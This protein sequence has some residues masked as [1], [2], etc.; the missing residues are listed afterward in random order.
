MR[1]RRSHIWG[2]VGMATALTVAML[3]GGVSVAQ[4]TGGLPS[5]RRAAAQGS[6]AAVADGAAVVSAAEAAAVT[7]VAWRACTDPSL[8]AAGVVCGSVTLPMDY[9]RPSGPKVRI[10]LSMLRHTVPA[11]KYQGVMLINPG[12]PGGSGL[13][14]AVLGSYVPNGAGAAYDWIGFDPRGVGSSTPRVICNPQVGAPPRPQYTP[15]SYA[16]VRAWLARAKAYATA[17]K[18]H[19][20]ATLLKNMRTVDVVRDMDGIRA[21]LGQSKLNFYGFSYGTYLGQ[22]YATRYPTRVRR[23]V[24]DGNVNPKRV[25]YNA[26]LDQ[27]IAFDKVAKI[28]FAWVARNN[29]VYHLGATAAIVEKAWYTQRDAFA[30]APAGG[31]VGASEWAD[32]FLNIGYGTFSWADLA[33]MW[34]T[35]ESD[36]QAAP[37]VAGYFGGSGVGDDNS[38]AVYLAV[39]CTDVKWPSR[40][41]TWNADNTRINTFAPFI[42]WGNA[43]MN[44]PCLYWPAKAG[45]LP[46]VSGKAAPPILLVSE[47]LDAATPYNGS[48][49]VRKRF[50][51]SRLIAVVGGTS[52]A[53]SLSGNLCVD[54]RIATYLSTGKLPARVTGNRADVACAPPA[55]PAAAPLVALPAA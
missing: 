37:L 38:Y 20:S 14:F 23:M 39:Q 15:T 53:N 31:I 1:V 33:S 11:K 18:D 26:N 21:A 46:T 12:G 41:S 7:K 47:T 44:A 43:W 17:C 34:S 28:W 29:S 19:N 32:L 35:Y 25:W 27:N 9:A 8:K 40:F 36:H 6:T 24:L 48:L 52:H 30:K 2:V 4:A 13:N 49:E 45:T 22:V 5:L 55:L 10:A 42:T 51:R 50:P 16:V 54:N 3:P